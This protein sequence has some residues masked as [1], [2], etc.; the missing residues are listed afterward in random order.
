MPNASSFQALV[1]LLRRDVAR[2]RS[3]IF[4]ITLDVLFG[5]LGLAVYFFISRTFGG[6]PHANLQ[7]APTYF[8][9]AAIGV[10]LTLVVQSA[11]AGLTF[12]L[13]EEQLTG[14]L[15]AVVAE[16]VRTPVLAVGLAGFVFAF[17]VVRAVLYVLVAYLAFGIDLPRASWLG[18]AVVL[19][20]AAVATLAIGIALASA[21]LIAK[22]AGGVLAS[23][24]PFALGFGGGAFFPINQLPGWLQ[25][26]A[27]ILPTR[28]M[29]TGARN[30]LFRGTDWAGDAAALAA[31]AVV[32]LPVALACFHGALALARREGT[33]SNY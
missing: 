22:R 2:N 15:E 26:I 9:F 14:T 7:G 31:F 25:P 3:Y 20:A 21:T 33:L 17:A 12:T 11:C 19:L 6:G 29:Y 1:A 16:P 10:A 5:L 23:L 30:A 18:F 13:R 8:A 4:A 24:V 32:L 27:E 28:F